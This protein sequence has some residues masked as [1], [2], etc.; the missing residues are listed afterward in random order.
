MGAVN[1]AETVSIDVSKKYKNVFFRFF[2]VTVSVKNSPEVFLSFII[3]RPGSGWRMTV[4]QE[5]C[6]DEEE[7]EDQ[8]DDLDESDNFTQLLEVCGR[9][10]TRRS[11][12][13]R[14]SSSSSSSRHPRSSS[15]A[16]GSL[17]RFIKKEIQRRKQRLGL[18]PRAQQRSLARIANL[19]V[20]SE[21]TEEVGDT[22]LLFGQ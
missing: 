1:S 8:D 10:G 3:S 18:L 22:K 11:R 4:E 21:D 12:H 16:L 2:T 19:N 15:S 13:P 9:S 7:E 14:S 5:V 20:G 17:R 6:G